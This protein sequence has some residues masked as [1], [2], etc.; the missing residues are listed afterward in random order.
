MRRIAPVPTERCRRL[1]PRDASRPGGPASGNQIS[2]GV[3]DAP[4]SPFIPRIAAIELQPANSIRCVALRDVLFHGLNQRLPAWRPKLAVT[5]FHDL[6]VMTGEYSSPEFRER[7][8]RLAKDAAER[9][10]RIIAVSHFTAAQAHE[11]LGVEWDR[12]RVVHHGIRMPNAGERTAWADR[13]ACRRNSEAQ[14]C[15]P[16][17]RRVRDN[18]TSMEAGF[19][20]ICGIW[21]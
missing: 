14:E 12:L 20:R 17:Y 7:F 6:F 5:T 2:L 9:S 16:S 10:D 8:T 21:S 3:P 1:L 19:G 11:L 4:T 18:A 13:S 15:R